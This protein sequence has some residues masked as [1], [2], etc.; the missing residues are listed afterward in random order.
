MRGKGR[1]RSKEWV[2]EIDRT[3]MS[4]GSQH[5]YAGNGYGQQAAAK[6]TNRRD[7]L[8]V[9]SFY[10]TRFLEEMSEKDLWYEFKKWGGGG[11]LLRKTE[12]RVT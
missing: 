10:F 4:E 6:R 8:D 11:S 1:E 12:I 7:A 5:N 2:R 3:L 9:V